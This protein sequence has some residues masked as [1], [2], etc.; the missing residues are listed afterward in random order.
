MSVASTPEKPNSA[1][2]IGDTPAARIRERIT[3]LEE[4]A[5]KLEKSARSQRTEAM[6]LQASLQEAVQQEC[7]LLIEQI[8]EILS[9]AST[10]NLEEWMRDRLL[11]AITAE[12]AEEVEPCQ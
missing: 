7:D 3:Q 1:A 10:C 4:A 6:E 2:S 12:G 8:D 11:E 9:I 5:E